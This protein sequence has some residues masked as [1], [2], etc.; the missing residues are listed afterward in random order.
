[1]VFG[2]SSSK[3][4]RLTSDHLP[5]GL[6]YHNHES[7]KG[8]N[9]EGRKREIKLVSWLPGFFIRFLIQNGGGTVMK[10]IVIMTSP[11]T[12]LAIIPPRFPI[13]LPQPARPASIILFPARNSPAI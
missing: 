4:L 10:K 8:G 7:M 2:L 6:I 3:P 5:S 12:S 13:K 9:E 11:I 1:M